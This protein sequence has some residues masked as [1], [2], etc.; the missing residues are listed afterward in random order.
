[1]S[2]FCIDCGVDTY[3]IHEYY[4]VHDGVWQDAGM[5]KYDGAM[6]CVGCLERRLGRRL[7][8]SDFTDYPINDAR[9]HYQSRRLWD[10]V[11]GSRLRRLNAEFFPPSNAVTCP[12]PAG[13][14]R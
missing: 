3:A 1:M 11:N 6:L 5:V 12:G 8:D 10:R 4:M 13:E 7:A 9:R 2:G 14:D